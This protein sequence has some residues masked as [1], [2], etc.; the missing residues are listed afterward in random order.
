MPHPPVSGRALVRL[1]VWVLGVSTSHV[2][3][4]SLATATCPQ[5]ATFVSAASGSTLDFGW[6]G[7]GHRLEAGRWRFTVGL[8]Q[9]KGD[10]NSCG[11][12]PITGLDDRSPHRCS[13]N[14]GVTCQHDGDCSGAGWCRAFPAAPIP[15]VA[16]GQGF[17]ITPS[18]NNSLSGTLDPADGAVTIELPLSMRAFVGSIEAP[19][20]TCV[21]DE[22]ADDGE[23]TGTCRG[24]SRDGQRCDASGRVGVANFGDTSLDCPPLRADALGALT[25][26]SRPVTVGTGDVVLR[27]AG[28][29]PRARAFGRSATRVVCDVCVDDPTRPCSKGEDCPGGACEGT[30]GAP[31]AINACLDGNCSS[32]DGVH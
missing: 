16:G 17:C 6:T 7:V 24:G 23:A 26:A 28:E 14:I 27:V 13:E 25:D 12:C 1:L 31:T 8:G 10:D 3:T 18:L 19:C 5:S 11:A 29:S 21:G 15:L 32:S 30:R 20:P 4:P 2:A 9:C 22:T